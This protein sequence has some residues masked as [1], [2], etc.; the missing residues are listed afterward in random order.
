MTCLL[1]IDFL[2]DDALRGRLAAWSLALLV[3]PCALIALLVALGVLPGEGEADV[4][5][6]GGVLPWVAALA[7]VTLVSMPVHELV[8]GALFC[9]MGGRGTRV[10][11]GHAAGML[12]AGCPGL[13][14]TRRR[15][16]AVLLGPAVVLGTAL[17][18]VPCALGFALLGALAAALHL[19]SC[20]GDVLACALALR[21]PGCTHVQDTERGV[22]LLAAR[23]G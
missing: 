1:D 15:F 4:L 8:H 10:R 20:A 9:L 6:G 2:A 14:L 18:A 13:V 5:L 17:L 23:R 7:A 19:S 16:V 21:M 11:Y 12:Y 22:R 3:A